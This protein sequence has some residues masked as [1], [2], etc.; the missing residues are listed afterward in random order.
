MF[1]R[2]SL[3]VLVGGEGGLNK[4]NLDKKCDFSVELKKENLKNFFDEKFGK[5]IFDTA[6][7]YDINI[8]SHLY[9]E[10]MCGKCENFPLNIINNKHL[11]FNIGNW[12]I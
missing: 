11:I 10:I 12:N 7:E 1:F 9:D 6:K 5:E 3:Q 2:N 4:F 8:F